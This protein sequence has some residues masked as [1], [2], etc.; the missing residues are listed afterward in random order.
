M[1]SY[2]LLVAF[3]ALMA[4]PFGWLGLWMVPLCSL[5]HLTLAGALYLLYM[6]HAVDGEQI[7]FSPDRYLGIEVVRGFS[8]RR[9]RM[10]PLWAHLE[11][12]GPRNERLWLCSGRL[13]IEVATQLPQADRKRVE[14]ELKRA[15]AEVQ[16]GRG[17]R[18]WAGEFGSSTPSAT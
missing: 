14:R 6:I 5:L 3:S 11:R 7:T 18:P 1:N 17:C 13:R 9:Y 2:L 12:G 4:L 15:L 8:T 16:S 10:N